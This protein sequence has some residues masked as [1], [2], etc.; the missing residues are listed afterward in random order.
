MNHPLRQNAGNR[1]KAVMAHIN[2]YTIQG[3]ARLAADAG[4]SR[5]AVSRCLRGESNPSFSLVMAMTTALEAQVG[6]RID[7]RELL[8]FDGRYPTP[9]VCDLVGCRGCLPDEV[10]ADD[11]TVKPEYR[12]VKPGA[13]N[14]PLETDPIHPDT[15]REGER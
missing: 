14:L 8:T 9:S 3:Q 12:H 1:I 15:S 5:S 13:W 10:Y 2:R 11:D 4:I 6:R 7:P